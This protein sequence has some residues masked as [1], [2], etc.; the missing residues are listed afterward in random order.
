MDT[1]GT[2]T[3]VYPPSRY[4]DLV[5]KDDHIMKFKQQLKDVENQPPINGGYFVF[6][7]EFLDYIPDD[8][9]VSLENEPVDAI[10]AR[11]QLTVYRH[12]DF[13]QCMDTYR[14]NQMLEALWKTSP[15]WKIW[16]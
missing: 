5:V 16:Q 14:D 8:S 4:G 6:K 1:I 10:V 9:R 2:L 12:T 3:G 13:W 11:N 15:P 7:R